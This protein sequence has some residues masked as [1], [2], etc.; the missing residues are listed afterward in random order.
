MTPL[1]NWKLL[2][3]ALDD[4]ATARVLAPGEIEVTFD[5]N[6][7]S[8][9]VVI[10]MTPD[11]WEDMW[12]V[13]WGDFGAA[14]DDVRSTLASLRSGENHAVFRQYRLEPSADRTLPDDDDFTPEPGGEWIHHDSQGRISRLADWVEPGTDGL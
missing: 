14:L 6:G 4:W 3:A 9:R 13:M 10:V 8:R 12:S 7:A 2:V 1:A 5:Q 11:E